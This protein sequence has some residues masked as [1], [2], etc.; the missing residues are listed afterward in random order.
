MLWN[1]AE[2]QAARGRHARLRTCVVEACNSL[3]GHESEERAQMVRRLLLW[4]EAA[5]AAAGVTERAAGW[6][7]RVGGYGLVSRGL[8][9]GVMLLQQ[10][11][12]LTLAWCCY[13][14][15]IINMAHWG[16]GVEAR[17]G[18]EAAWR[19]K[20]RERS[21]VGRG[22]QLCSAATHLSLGTYM[23]CVIT[24]GRRCLIHGLQ[25]TVGVRWPTPRRLR[26]LDTSVQV[27][28]PRAV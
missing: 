22:R 14:L 12:S 2:T 28:S 27:I 24:H 6:R 13:N 21:S 1:L 3:A 20:Q 17:G 16:D 4:R 26:D 15:N 25:A 11:D 5:E 10:S 18:W 19:Q 23:L 7:A 9:T 8:G